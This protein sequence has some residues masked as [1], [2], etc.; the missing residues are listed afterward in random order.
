MAGKTK[1]R[2]PGAPKGNANGRGNLKHGLRSHLRHGL[3]IGELPPGC[4][5]ISNRLNA[6]RRALEDAVIA[7]WG[8]VDLTSASL[9]QTVLRHEMTAQLAMRW[10]RLEGDKLNLHDR[11]KYTDLISKASRDR[12]TAILQLEISSDILNDPWSVLDEEDSDE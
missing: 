7:T 8:E 5:Y 4:R 11:L 3:K 10:L 1:K 6:L 12:D 9:I 2:G